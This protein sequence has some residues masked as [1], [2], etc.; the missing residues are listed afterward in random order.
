MSFPPKVHGDF[1]NPVAEFPIYASQLRGILRVLEMR[2]D[3]SRFVM[4]GYEDTP[5][6]NFE[7]AKVGVTLKHAE[8]H[9]YF[10]RVLKDPELP[11]VQP[12]VS[13]QVEDLVTGYQ[14]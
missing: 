3:I 2:R 9:E 13:K 7:V 14:E 10:I 12:S 4:L 5:Q 6:G 11:P 8:H 1:K